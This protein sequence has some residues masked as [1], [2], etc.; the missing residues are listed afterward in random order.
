MSTITIWS[1]SGGVG[2]TTTTLNLAA[3]LT[4]SGQRVL[5]VDLDPQPASV[6]D[7]A[8]YGH[9]KTSDSPHLR[10]AL[11]EDSITLQ[12]IIIPGDYDIVPAH[13][14]LSTL[15]GAAR[16][17]RITMAEFLLKSELAEVGDD[18][19]YILIDPPATLSLLV[20]NALIASDH[21]LIP[22]ELTP[23]GERSVDGVIDTVTALA[24]QLQRAQPDF[25]LDILGV[26]PNRVEQ[27][28]VT[29]SVRDRLDTRDV[30]VIPV[31]IPDYNVFQK[32]WDAHTDIFAYAAETDLRSYQKA[33][34]DAYSELAAYVIVET[35]ASANPL[36]TPL[37]NADD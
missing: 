20:D 24:S 18:Y 22:T 36:R 11:I 10:D 37:P 35:T 31:T 4:N 2:K 8:G 27:N 30:P 28:T 14:A 33:V 17:A 6:T 5:I 1:E 15:E 25:E 3:A 29:Q 13:E 7:H 12:D 9:V 21:V 19:D 34:L 23:K 26:L 32:S 16:D